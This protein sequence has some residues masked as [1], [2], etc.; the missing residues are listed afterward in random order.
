MTPD[1]EPDLKLEI[2]YLLCIDVVGYSKLLV[3]E[4]VELMQ[5]LVGL[6]DERFTTLRSFWRAM[7]GEYK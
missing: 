6:N 1:V 5:E 7:A 2:A 3:N 4:R